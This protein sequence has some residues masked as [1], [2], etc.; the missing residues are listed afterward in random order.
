[1][2][3][4][5]C[6]GRLCVD[7]RLTLAPPHGCSHDPLPSHVTRQVAMAQRRREGEATVRLLASELEEME[8]AWD[9]DVSQHSIEQPRTE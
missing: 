3:M 2:A 6:G 9:A 5:A 8:A 4:R 7:P 1:M